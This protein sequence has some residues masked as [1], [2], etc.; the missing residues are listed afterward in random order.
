[1]FQ[2]TVEHVRRKT[3]LSSIQLNYW[4][5]KLKSINIMSKEKIFADGFSFKRNDNAPQFVVG[6]LSMKVEEAI[7]F[8]KSNAKNGW[9]N[10]DVK[11]AQSGN[12]YCELDTWEAKPQGNNQAK[13]AA[14]VEPVAAAEDGEDLPF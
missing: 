6:R 5:K 11:Q 12:Y 7:V 2:W 10:V 9:V 8:L 4:S 1:M 13:P 14:R 3:I